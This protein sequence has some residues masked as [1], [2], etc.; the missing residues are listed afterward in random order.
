[1]FFFFSRAL[2][3][4]TKRCESALHD[5]S[6]LS[7]TRSAI[8]GLENTLTPTRLSRASQIVPTVMLN[9]VLLLW[10]AIHVF[11]V[12]CKDLSS[13]Q[14]D[15]CLRA[16]SKYI[17][18][19]STSALTFCADR[20]A[21]ITSV[22]LPIPTD[23]ARCGTS[24]LK[25]NSACNCL[26][27]TGISGTPS[28]ELA[29]ATVTV[30]ETVVLLPTSTA[31]LIKPKVF[32]VSLFTPE[33]AVWIEPLSLKINAAST[34]SAL[35]HSRSFDLSSTYFLIAGIAGVNPECGTLGS[36]NFAKYLVQVGLSYEI[37]MRELPSNYSS[38]YVPLGAS[39]PG[40]YPLFL[41]GTEVFELNSGLRDRAFTLAASRT[42]TDSADAR[43]YRSRYPDSPANLPPRVIKGDT[44]TSDVFFHGKLLGDTFAQYTSLLT[45][46]SGRYCMTAQEDNAILEAM[47]RG[48]LANLVDFARIVSMRTGSNFD[49]P[50]PGITA[51]QELFH[52]QQGG[53][54]IS[55]QNI[56]VAG[57]PIVDDIIENWDS[58][59]ANGIPTTHYIGDIL[60]SI[61]NQAFAPD[62]G[63]LYFQEG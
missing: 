3:K 30:T 17:A 61:K 7:A 62:I 20:V 5:R 60:G 35:I 53:F 55:I 4:G 22:R 41:Y 38:G 8:S 52:V 40:Q 48:A 58:A 29:G 19:S 2:P 37:D 51:A 13:C 21:T 43:A 50:P 54:D 44:T 24:S 12:N 63:S 28:T 56:Y 27:P 10:I 23:L 59:Y 36:V 46:G 57:R 42:L 26:M 32:I 14:N 9:L 45:N 31:S 34:V 6:N 18:I 39:N 33:A 1:M 47:L 49:R 15:D 16:L 11:T 25:I